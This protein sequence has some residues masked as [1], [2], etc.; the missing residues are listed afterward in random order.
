[1]IH[2]MMTLVTYVSILVIGWLLGRS[3]SRRGLV[4]YRRASKRGPREAT[5][6]I[7]VAFSGRWYQRALWHRFPVADVRAARE[8][9]EN[10]LDDTPVV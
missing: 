1:M 7:W 3:S 2:L 10:N 5:G 6:H 4:F 8:A 9:A